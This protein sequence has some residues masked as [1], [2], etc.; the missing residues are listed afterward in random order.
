MRI[1]NGEDRQERRRKRY[2]TPIIYAL[3]EITLAWLLISIAMIDFNIYRWNIWGKL[4]LSITTIYSIH[5]MFKIYK[6]QKNYK[7]DK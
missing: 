6:R 3:S 5:K 7:R 2:I 1:Y 4:I